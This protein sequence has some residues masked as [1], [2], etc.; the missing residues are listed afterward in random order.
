MGLKRNGT[1]KSPG[2]RGTDRAFPR[3]R[4]RGGLEEL[5]N[6]NLKNYLVK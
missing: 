2:G 5:R 1:K 3:V 6:I 4:F